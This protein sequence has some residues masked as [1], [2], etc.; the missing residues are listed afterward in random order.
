VQREARR[1]GFRGDRILVMFG[2]PCDS[3]KLLPFLRDTPV[4]LPAIT[5]DVFCTAA[6]SITAD[7]GF[8]PMFWNHRGPT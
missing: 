5:D 3:L 1:P 7:K 6:Q 2:A 8:S 4:G